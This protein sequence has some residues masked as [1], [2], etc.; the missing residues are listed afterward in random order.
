[1]ITIITI[2]ITVVFTEFFS[3]GFTFIDSFNPY[4]ILMF[5]ILLSFSSID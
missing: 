4:N 5:L 3:K 2:T 1:M